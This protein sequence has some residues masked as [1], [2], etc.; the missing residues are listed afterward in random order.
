MGL[1]LLALIIFLLLIIISISLDLKRTKKTL[2]EVEENV[3]K[4]LKRIQVLENK[5]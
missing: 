1:V 2:L 5:N 4:L 3:D